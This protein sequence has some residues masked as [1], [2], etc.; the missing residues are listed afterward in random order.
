[1]RPP[2]LIS[3]GSETMLILVYL[4]LVNSL[5]GPTGSLSTM[6]SASDFGLIFLEHI[7]KKEKESLLT[8]LSTDSFYITQRSPHTHTF[9]TSLYKGETSTKYLKTSRSSN[10]RKSWGSLKE[11]NHQTKKER[12]ISLKIV[13]PCLYFCSQISQELHIEFKIIC[14]SFIYLKP[15]GMFLEFSF[16]MK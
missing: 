3:N 1:M 9:V 12:W 10:S 5:S 11:C 15:S 6:W 4:Y 8:A 13:F 14:S 16:H 7:Q 2:H